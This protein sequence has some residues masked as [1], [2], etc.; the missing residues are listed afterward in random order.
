[1]EAPTLRCRSCG[2][3][4]GSGDVRCPYCN[5][6][7]ATISCP[8]CFAMVSLQ[9]EHCPRCGAAVVHHEAEEGR[10]LTCPACKQAL[11][12]SR[13]GETT[14]DQCSRC[15]GAWL[16][17]EA[18]DHLVERQE[19]RASFLDALPEA[20]AQAAVEAT[21]AFSYRPC[22]ACAKLMNRSNYARV[23]GVIVDTCR[24]HGIWF[25]KDELRRVLAFIQDGGLKRA[26]QHEQAALQ[27]ERD[28]L[29]EGLAESKHGLGDPGGWTAPLAPGPGAGLLIGEILAGAA[30]TLWDGIRN[31]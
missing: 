25:D 9:D 30:V 4:L 26:A 11:L 8:Q 3:P 5:S 20:R 28:R 31:R 15:G 27:A 21:L 7:V 16:A 23:S 14:L 6:Q 17:R 1:M 24:E 12:R 22:P 2:G 29:K 19:E 18:F 13:V 10:S